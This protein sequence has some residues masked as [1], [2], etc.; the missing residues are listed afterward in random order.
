MPTRIG[1]NGFGRI[2]RVA[3]RTISATYRGGLEIVA[4][5]DLTDAKTNA[6]L[7]QH[8]SSYGKFPGDIDSEDNSLLVN[9]KRIQ[10][11]HEREPGAIPWDQ[12]GVDI[13]LEVTGLFTDANKAR[14]H[15]ERG[16]KKVVIGAPAKNE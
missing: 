3:F 13:V 1:I 6:F 15:L 10:V 5:N 11:F 4:I 2:G 14:A 9:G 7:L 16:V 12:E 8:D